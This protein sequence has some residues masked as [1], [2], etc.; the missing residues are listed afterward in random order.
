MKK[1]NLI[2]TIIFAL[3]AMAL[4]AFTPVTEANAATQQESSIMAVADSLLNAPDFI[5]QEIVQT[6]WGAWILV[7]IGPWMIVLFFMDKLVKLTPTPYDD[8]I[9]G[10]LQVVGKRFKRF[11]RK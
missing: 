1:I 9:V 8:L 7:Y 2:F 6:S 5:I 10:L 3:V 4:F 11:S